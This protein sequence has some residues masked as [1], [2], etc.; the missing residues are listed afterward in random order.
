MSNAPQPNNRSGR[1]GQALVLSGG[2]A[3]GCFQAAAAREL[4]RAGYRP[5]LICGVSV[6]AINAIKLAEGTQEAAD[7]LV[8]LWL[9][10]ADKKIQIQDE[11][12]VSEELTER[13]TNDIVNVLIRTV[14]PAVVGAAAVP[15]AGALA[16]AGALAA[17]IQAAFAANNLEDYIATELKRVH[18]V[19]SYWYKDFPGLRGLLEDEI[20]LDAIVESGIKLRIGMTD[21]ESGSYWNATEPQPLTNRVA[22]PPFRFPPFVIHAHPRSR[23][24]REP[25]LDASPVDDRL[26]FIELKDAVYASA[27]VPILMPPFRTWEVKADSDIQNSY[28]VYGDQPPEFKRFLDGDDNLEDTDVN[29]H[30]QASWRHFFDGGLT[31]ITPIRTAIRLGY[32]EITVIGTSPL[33]GL[34]AWRPQTSEEKPFLGPTFEYLLRFI[35]VWGKN[36]ARDD[37]FQALSYNEF[38]SWLHQLHKELDQN[39]AQTVKDSFEKYWNDRAVGWH[40]TLGATSWI[41][42][43]EPFGSQTDVI[44]KPFEDSGCRIRV[45]NPTSPLNLGVLRI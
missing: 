5:D 21:L 41:G 38:M 3:K 37:L 30:L 20:N 40:S 42:G 45:I 23:L 16:V 44:G 43:T 6:G 36:I 25:D 13:V 26:R 14:T 9:E 29:Q 28:M 18:S 33:N 2:G 35:D 11:K 32:R 10:L 17:G 15:F 7:R 19:N 22:T 4:F 39:T 12:R 34:S 8:D 27:A 31:D 24:I 1:Q